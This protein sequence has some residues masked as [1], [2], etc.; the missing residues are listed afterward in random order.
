[1]W[2]T[3]GAR[4]TLSGPMAL[5]G[6]RGESIVAGQVAMATD[7]ASRRT[8]PTGGVGVPDRWSAVGIARGGREGG[9]GRL[10]VVQDAADGRRGERESDSSSKYCIKYRELQNC[11]LMRSDGWTRHFR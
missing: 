9:S 7:H 6:E 1:M 4:S 3:N 5:P 8:M 10:T 11:A 2:T